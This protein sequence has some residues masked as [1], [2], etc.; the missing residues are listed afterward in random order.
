[1]ITL[2]CVVCGVTFRR[3]DLYHCVELG[4]IIIFSFCLRIQK[5]LHGKHTRHA[6]DPTFMGSINTDK[7]IIVYVSNKIILLRVKVKTRYRSVGAIF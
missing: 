3:V 5:Q 4:D 7:H 6:Q 2:L 1:M